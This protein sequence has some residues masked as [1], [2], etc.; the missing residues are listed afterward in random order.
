MNGVDMCDC[1]AG[2]TQETPAAIDNRP[3]LAE[4]AY[5]VGTWA[6]F[7]ASMLDALSTVPALAAL[8]TR[9][10]DDFTIALCD[11]FAVVC[12]ILTFYYERSAN[13]HYLRTA[14]QLVSIAE[15]AALI[16]YEPA[17]GVA[18]S[19]ALAF[20]LEAPPPALPT[21]PRPPQPALVPTAISLPSGLQVQSVPGPG[22][23]PVTFETVAPITARY[24]WNALSPRLTAPYANDERNGF[25][26]HLRL[27]GLIGTL[28]TGDYVLIVVT[29]PNDTLTGL[30]RVTS[31]AQDTATQTSLVT[32]ER[33]AWVTQDPVL[34]PDPSKFGS[35]L[36]GSPTAATIA[37]QVLGVTWNDQTDFV[38]QAQKLQWD[39]DA[40]QAL[41]NA[42]G[43]Q[44][45][46]NP[47]FS[48][49]KLGVRASVF[50]HNAPY[51]GTLPS[52]TLQSGQSFPADWETYTLANLN[53]DSSGANVQLDST[54]S[55]LVRGT[56]VVLLQDGTSQPARVTAT[57]TLTVARFLLSAS[58]T[59]VTLDLDPT[60]LGSFGM[61]TTLVLG[62]SDT[63]TPA[64]EFLDGTTIGGSQIT[65]DSAQLGLA[66]GQELFLTGTSA[67][68]TGSTAN[69]LRTI[70]ALALIDGRTQIT[71]DRALDDTYLWNSVALNANVAPA[72]HGASRSQI[73]GSGDATQAYQRFA[74]NQLPVTYVSAATPS[75]T[76][77]TLQV[78]VNGDLW[79]EVPYLYG[80]SPTERVFVTNVDQNGNRFVEFGDGVENGARLPTGTNNVIANYRQGLGSAGNVNASQLSTLLTR[81]LG[82]RSA[83]NPVAATGGGDPQTLDDARATAP[84]TVRALDRVVSLD[85][86]GD[87]A[88]ASAAVGKAAAVWAWDGV[89][90][91]VCIT[92]SG[93]AG[94]PIVPGTDQYTNL[95]GAI[96]NAGDGTVPVRLCSYVPRTFTVG[97]TLT[98]DPALDPDQVVANAKAALQAAYSFSARAFMQPIYRSEVIA[99]LQ[100][101]AG[102]VA[103]TLDTLRFNDNLFELYLLGA[104]DALTA[105]PPTM[106][107]GSLTGAE[108]LTIDGGP[109][110]NVV[111]A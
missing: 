12:D 53:P 64:E 67:T 29:I 14:T 5:R 96:A 111:H 32:F 23:Q 77:S 50:G 38:A 62:A 48:V 76:A 24:A 52:Y 99:T 101:V 63:F 16:G 54:Y 33:E 103:L 26:T 37:S 98:V 69:E 55:A 80:H 3:G 72:T 2:V 49:F 11:A 60:V 7:K 1:C 21:K 42:V 100:N 110:P 31:V 25:P 45:P 58:V 4:I 17:P 88:S 6:Q 70:Q 27:Q 79:T 91:V 106:I 105:A 73:L 107:G 18:A 13:E 90:Q 34:R 109:L 44:A 92:V 68:K 89:R 59:Q 15:L 56:W 22:E 8:K 39:L 75:T 35:V 43:T 102:V 19:A 74:L 87:F 65:L 9:D 85:D 40:T 71:L 78:R 47:P 94:S 10:D 95:L 93:P 84:I 66:V 86:F 46:G 20:T 104:T 97:A 108:L 83:I 36:S 57:T 61:R 82:L 30:N 41:I 81:P 51:Y 28:Q